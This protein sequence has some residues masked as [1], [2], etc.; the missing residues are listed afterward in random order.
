MAVVRTSLCHVTN[1]KKRQE[2]NI[3]VFEF[4]FL[5]V[6]GVYGGKPSSPTLLIP[7]LKHTHMM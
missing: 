5:G 4:D 2:Y 7:F 3:H 6:L 1:V